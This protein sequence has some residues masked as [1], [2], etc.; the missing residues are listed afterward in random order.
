MRLQQILT[1]RKGN[2]ARAAAVHGLD[3]F[4]VGIDGAEAL[5]KA[6]DAFL[7]LRRGIQIDCT[8]DRRR[9]R[10]IFLPVLC[11]RSAGDAAELRLI[12]NDPRAGCTLRADVVGHDGNAGVLQGLHMDAQS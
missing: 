8:A 12:C 4:K 3:N 7:A 5:H 6:V 1:G 10:V 2:R 11:R 9:I